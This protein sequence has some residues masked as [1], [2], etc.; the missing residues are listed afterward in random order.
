[1]SHP[2]GAQLLDRIQTELAEADVEI[3][4]NLVDLAEEESRV[5]D[6]SA[7]SQTL[8]AAEGV[9]KDLSQRLFHARLSARLP[10]YRRG[11]RLGTRMAPETNRLR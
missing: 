10:K 9:L 8:A 5:G 7:A 11:F 1:M 2:L 3:G 4:F 6:V